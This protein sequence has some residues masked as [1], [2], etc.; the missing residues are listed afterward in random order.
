MEEALKDYMMDGLDP[1]GDDYTINVGEDQI[2][3]SY[4]D[5]TFVLYP[6]PHGDGILKIDAGMAVQNGAVTTF[7]PL[8][9][10]KS[11]RLADPTV[12]DQVAAAMTG[13]LKEGEGFPMD[14]GT[15]MRM[16]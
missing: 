6:D 9:T 8:Y 1:P 12:L 3:I 15:M 11:F 4:P 13:M 5:I 14:D 7:V 10:S 2:T 16:I